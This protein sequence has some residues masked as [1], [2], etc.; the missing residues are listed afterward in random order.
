MGLNRTRCRV[1][2]LP[3]YT[4][5]PEGTGLGLAIT[6]RIVREHAG[7]IRVE[8]E[9]HRGTRFCIALPLVDNCDPGR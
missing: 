8:S 2:S 9:L 5:K 1:S 6:Q 7:D 4:T 3:S